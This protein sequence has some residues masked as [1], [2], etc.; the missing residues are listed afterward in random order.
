MIKDIRTSAKRPLW[1]SY[2]R[3]LVHVIGDI[4][5][6]QCEKM[7]SIGA[8]APMALGLVAHDYIVHL[9]HH[10]AQIGVA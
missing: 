6:S 8:K 4:P 5:E 2:N 7:C 10:L 9:H 3:H 1:D